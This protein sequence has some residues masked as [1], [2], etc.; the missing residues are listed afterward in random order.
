[1]G[2]AFEKRIKGIEDQRKKQ[3]ETL[4]GLKPKAIE[5]EPTNKPLISKEIYDK[6]LD[7]RM[8]EILE[9]SREINFN[10]SISFTEFGGPMY[11][12]N[13]L[14]NGDKPQVEE[15]QKELNQN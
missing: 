2:K 9:I 14:K 1:M 15:D 5:S 7:E 12:Y 13:Q 8:D 10:N 3:V 4:E 6:L 11:F